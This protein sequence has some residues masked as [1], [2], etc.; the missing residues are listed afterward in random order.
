MLNTLLIINRLLSLVNHHHFL[1][2]LSTVLITF[3]DHSST[4]Q[5]TAG[6]H[7]LKHSNKIILLLH[8]EKTC[9]WLTCLPF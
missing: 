6:I 4:D 7:F 9:L 2:S 8:L 5:W 3:Y 1:S